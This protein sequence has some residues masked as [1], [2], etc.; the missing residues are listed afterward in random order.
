MQQ[1]GIRPIVTDIPGI[2][3]AIMAYV[4]GNIVDQV[5]RLH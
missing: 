1:A 2:D 5:D 3:E 4:V